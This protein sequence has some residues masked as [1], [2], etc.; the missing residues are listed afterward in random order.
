[1]TSLENLVNPVFLLFAALTLVALA[2]LIY[3]LWRAGTPR[4][5]RE[6]AMALHRA[7][8]GELDRDLAEGR[9]SPI[10]H[11]GAR[12]EVQRRL[13]AVADEADEAPKSAARLPLIL[14]LIIVPL[15][16]EGLYLIDGHPDLPSG[17]PADM[18]QSGADPQEA[19]KLISTLRSRLGELD[20]KTEIA[21]EGYVLL[22]NAE[23]G[24]GHI[25]EAA[26]A[27]KMAL[28]AGFNPALAAQAAD[29]QLQADGKMTDET[30]ALFRRALAEAPPDAP[31]R[32][33][34]QQRLSA[35]GK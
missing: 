15:A 28:Q 29:A 21:S 17:T 34:V 35:A 16:A 32:S 19:E 33:L 11:S 5:R 8:L 9:I 1:V 12:L 30:A 3:R 18:A 31:W 6:A 25:G 13:L 7:Q 14:A 22:G 23:A 24:R 20:P 26:A 2:P 10:E 27:W 4:G